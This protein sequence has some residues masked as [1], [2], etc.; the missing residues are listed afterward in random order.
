[1]A[2]YLVDANLPYYFSVWNTP[3]FIHVKDLDDTWSDEK[4]WEY[5][6]TNQL[7]IITKDSDFSVKALFT[8]TFPKVIHIRFGNLKFS[9][10]HE[11]ISK[12]WKRID[13]NMDDHKLA[14]VFKDTVEF[15]K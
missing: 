4:I 11:T 8:E 3:D 12:F 14:N 6:K 7:I 15:V 2:R 1:M 5:A 13:E 9:V 10:F